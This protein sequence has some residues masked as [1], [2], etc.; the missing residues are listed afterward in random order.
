MDF[1]EWIAQGARIPN[2]E[3]TLCTLLHNRDSTIEL[4]LIAMAL[5]QLRSSESVP[6]LIECLGVQE[7]FY[8]EHGMFPSAPARRDK[9]AAARSRAGSLRMEAAYARGELRDKGPSRLWEIASRS[10]PTRICGQALCGHSGTLAARK[11]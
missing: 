3:T 11:R 6:V 7:V 2:V 4:G 9:A 1:D 5:G 8:D 10:S